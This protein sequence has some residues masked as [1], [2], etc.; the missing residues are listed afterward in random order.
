LGAYVLKHIFDTVNDAY[1]FE[2]NL[3]P[4]AL[5]LEDYIFK[6]GA[7]MHFNSDVE[8]VSPLQTG[9]FKIDYSSHGEKY[10][11]QVENVV[12]T[13]PLPLCQ[14]VMPSMEIVSDVIYKPVVVYLTQ[15]ELRHPERSLII[16]M[17]ALD[18]GNIRIFSTTLEYEH[19]IIPFDSEKDVDFNV[20]YKNNS[21][22]VLKKQYLKYGWPVRGPKA[23]VP[24]LVTNIKGAYLCGDFYYYGLME[25]SVCT[26]QKV[27]ELITSTPGGKS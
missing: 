22:R 9:G 1:V 27:A 18:K 8:L 2:E 16:G 14:K 15:G 3:M 20:L 11:D 13:L 21:C 23:R 19:I 25:T 6:Q 10:S 5:L 26:A 12:L 24:E 17:R 4:M 7:E